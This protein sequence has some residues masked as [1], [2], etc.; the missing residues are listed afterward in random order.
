MPHRLLRLC[1]LLGVIFSLNAMADEGMWTYDNFPT[2]RMQSKYGWAPDAAWLRHAQLSS[3]RLAQGCSASLVSRDGLVMTNHHCA[4][5]CLSELADAKHD[6]IAN[7]FYAAT[8]SDEKRCPALEANQLVEI[9]DVTAQVKAATAG[10]SGQAFHDAEREAKAKLESQCGTAASVRCE[11]VMLY[12]GGVYDLYRYKRYQDLR[13]VFAPEESAAFFGGDPDNFT[14]PRYDLDTSF[15]RI[16]DQGKPLRSDNYLKFA[17]VGVKAGDIALTS[18]NPGSTER[19]DTLAQLELQRDVAQPFLLEEL[20]ELRGTLTEFATKGPEQAR[21]SKFLLFITENSLKA[22]KGRQLALVEGPLMAD[23]ARAERDF[24]QRVAAD[25]KL[26][27]DT[28]GAWDAIAAA[29]THEHDIYVRYALLERLAPR[30]SDL[31]K[32][33]VELNRY[34]A[35]SVKPDGQRLHEYSDANFPALKQSITSPAPIHAALEKTVLTWWLTKVREQLGTTDPD[36]ITLLGKRSPAE[37]AD[38]LVDGTRLKDVKVRAQLLAGGAKVIDA[39]HDP[40]LEF[41]R[42][43]DGPARAVR[44]D[45]ENNVEAV[46]A[47]NS[48]LIADARFALEGKNT[49]PDAT[50]TLRLSYGAVDGYRENGHT[51]APTTSFAGAYAHATGRDPFKLPPT[52]LEAQKA[53]NGATNLDFVSTNDIIGGNSGSPVIGRDG[54]VIGLIFDGNIQSLGGDFGYDESVNRA[55]A[56]DVTGINEALKNIYHADRLVRELTAR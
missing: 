26:K 25:P 18:G 32:P 43:L 12:H 40:L 44:M 27:A 39:D 51:V 15:V 56:V 7:G 38:A 23:K 31:L 19:E 46:V 50:F 35:E 13:V 14:F 48:A 33:A 2:Q 34:A 36:T 45:Y 6:Y 21:T 52:W 54:Q 24:R 37:I 17:T 42:T 20:S 16:Y 1:A 8:L 28:G 49:Y 3:I 47:K 55:I 53:V 10:K 29:M 4:R 5:D 30:L 11:V 41:A 22:Y 9:T